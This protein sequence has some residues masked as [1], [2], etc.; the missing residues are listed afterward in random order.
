MANSKRKKTSG[1]FVTVGTGEK[2]HYNSNPTRSKPKVTETQKQAAEARV[3]QY[4]SAAKENASTQSGLSKPAKITS[5]VSGEAWT[6]ATPSQVKLPS[7]YTTSQQ[8]ELNRLQELRRQAQVDLDTDTLNSVDKRMKELRAQ[9]GKQTRF[10]RVGSVL[11]GS[12]KLYAGQLAGTAGTLVEGAGKLN[13]RIENYTDRE[14]LQTAEDNINRYQQMLSSGKDLTGKALTAEDR[15][16][17]Q[18]YIKHNQAVLDAHKNYTATVE[19]AD[20]ET[21]DTLYGKSLDLIDSG[22]K[23]VEK[24][25]EDLGFVGRAAVDLGVAGTQMAADAALGTL[26]G[27]ALIP[28]FIR[29]FGGG[30]IEAKQ[31]G[32]TYG[33]QLAY[34]ALSAGTE[35]ATEKISNVSG[36]FKKVYGGGVVDE[37][38]KKAVKKLSSNAVGQALL[39]AGASAGGEGFEEFVSD[40]FAPIWQRA[41]YAKDPYASDKYGAG[42]IDLKSRPQ[43]QNAD[44]TISTV[45]SWSFNIDGKEVLLPS[46]WMKDGKPYRSSNADEILRHYK[47]TGEYLGKFDTVEQANAYAEKLHQEQNQYYNVYQNAKFDL[48]EAMYDA[49]IGAAMGLIGD[50]GNIVNTTRQASVDNRGVKNAGNAVDV[51]QMNSGNTVPP[52]DAQNQNGY[53]ETKVSPA[54]SAQVQQTEAQAQVTRA[55]NPGS[56]VLDAATTLFTQQGMKLKTAQEKAAIVQKLIAGEEVSVRDI[57]KLNPTSKE[58][59]AIFTQLTGVQFPEGKV[60]QEQLYNLYRSANQVAVD[61]REKQRAQQAAQEAAFQQAAMERARSVQEQQETPAAQE[62]QTTDTLT[63]QM[64]D[65]GFQANPET[66]DRIAQAQA[67]LNDAVNGTATAASRKTGNVRNSLTLK[68]GDTLTRDQFKQVM[69]ELYAEKGVNLTDNQLDAAFNNFLSTADRGGDI[70]GLEAMAEYLKSK[71]EN[72]NEAEPAGRSVPVSGGLRGESDQGAAEQ[73]QGVPDRD[74]E[75]KGTNQTGSASV[76]GKRTDAGRTGR[77]GKVQNRRSEALRSDDAGAPGVSGESEAVHDTGEV[78]GGNGPT[79]SGGGRADE[80]R[81]LS[82]SERGETDEAELKQQE[83]FIQ[84]LRKKRPPVKRVRPDPSFQYV[85]VLD[86]S[87]WTQEMLDLQKDFA[88]VGVKL[89]ATIGEIRSK[90]GITANGVALSGKAFAR[91]DHPTRTFKRS[92][93][94]ELIHE[95][96]MADNALAGQ[97]EAVLRMNVDSAKLNDLVGKYISLYQRAYTGLTDAEMKLRA[98]EEIICDAYSGINRNGWGATEYSDDIRAAVSSWEKVWDAAHPN[99]YQNT[100]QN[101]TAQGNTG[102]PSFSLTTEMTWDEQLDELDNSSRFSALYI[103]ETPNILAEVGLGDLPLCMTKAHMKDALHEKDPSNPHWHGVPEGVV[104]RLPDLLSKPAMIL[105]SK[106]TPGD[107]VVVLQA[108]DADGNPIVATIRPNGSA[109]VDKVAGPAN[110]ITS[111]YGRDNFAPKAG[112]TSKNNLLYL[113]LRDR[114]IMYWN[115][116]RTETLAHRCRL[117]LPQTLRKV[118]SDTILKQYEGY[119]KGNTPQRLFSMDDYDD[120]VTGSPDMD[121]SVP[122]FK[123]WD[124]AFWH[125]ENLAGSNLA[126]ADPP[127]M[128]SEMEFGALD[129]HGKWHETLGTYSKDAA[130]LAKFNED[131]KDFITA[132]ELSDEELNALFPPTDGDFADD[133]YG[134]NYEDQDAD[135]PG[136]LSDIYARSQ[137]EVSDAVQTNRDGFTKTDTKAFQKWF[138]DPSGE[139]TNPDGQPKVFLRGSIYMGATKAHEAG[140]AKSKGIFFTTDPSVAQEYAS[141]VSS[142]E[143]TTL[144][145][146]IK[147]DENL[148]LKELPRKYFRGWGPAKDYILRHFQAYGNGLRLVG[149]DANGNEVSRISDAETFSLQ[150]NAATDEQFRKEGWF[151]E[152]KWRELASFPKTKQ[153][154]EDFNYRLGD[155]IRENKLG[156]RGY[157]KYFLTSNNTLVVDAQGDDYHGIRSGVLPS[158][159][160]NGDT[161]VHINDIAE[162]AFQNGYDAVVV[163]NVDDAGGAQT[164]YIV[165]D[166]NQVKSV[167]NRGTWDKT[168]PDFL[169]DMA[170]NDDH[171]QKLEDFFKKMEEEYGGGSAEAMFQTFEQLDRARQ[172]AEERA[173]DAEAAQQAAEW[174]TEA[175]VEAARMAERERADK[176]LQKQKDAFQEKA[177]QKAAE[178][179]LSKAKAVKSARLAEQMNAGRQWAAKLRRQDER[180]TAKAEAMRKSAEE[181]MS[182][183][184]SGHQQELDDTRLAE[185]MNAGRKVAEAKRKGL[186]AVA[187]EKAKREQD[188]KLASKDAKTAASVLRKYHKADTEKLTNAPVSTLREAYHKPTAKDAVKAAADKLRTAHREFYKAFIN[189][190]QAVDDFSKYQKVDAN[191]SVL[192]RTAMASGSTVQS[193]RQD[194]LV[195]KDGSVIDDRSLE[196]VVICWDGSGKH[197]KYND[198]KQRILQDYMLHRHNVDRMSFREKALNAVESYEQ[199]YPWLASLEPREFA[200]LVADGN[201]IAQRYQELIEQ[202]QKAKDK[203]IFTDSEGKPV[204]AE[205]SRNLV[206]QYEQQ[207]DWVKEKAEGIYDWWD[208]FMQEWVVGDSLSAEEYA[209]LRE[210]YPSYVPTYRKDKPGLGKGVSSFGGTVTAKKAVRAATGGTSAVAN[211]EDSFNML[212]EK[213]VSSQRTN[214]VLRSITDTAMLD[215]AGD[216]NGF[217]V[218]DWNEAPEILRWGLAAEGFEG[219]LEAGTDQAAAKALSKDDGGVYRVRAWANGERVSAIV[220]P[221]LY[222][223]LDFAFNQKTGWFTK[224]GQT[225]TS[226]MKTFITGINPAFAMRN[227]IRDNLTAQMNSISVV[228]SISGIK[229]EKYY[230]KAWQEM[231][232]GSENWQHFVALGGTNAGYYNNEGGTYITNLNRQ[233]MQDLNPVNKVGKALGFI[234]EH[235]EQVTRFAEYL[236]TIDRLPG[237]DTYGNRLVGIKNAAEVTVDFSRKGTLGKAFNAWIPY[238]NPTVQGIDKTVRTFFDQ[239][240]VAGKAKVL[241]RAALTTLP[242]DILLF[243]IYHALDRDDEWEELSDRTKDT[244]YC[245]PLPDE[246]K[247]LKIPKSRDWGQIIGNPIMRMLQGLDGREDPFENYFEVSIK[248]NFLWSNPLDAVLLSTQYDLAKNEDFAGRAIVPSNYQKMAKGD[249]WNSDTSKYAKVIADIGNMFVEEDVLSPMQIDYVINDYFGDFGSMFQRLFSIGGND[250]QASA[251]EQAKMVAEDLLGNWVADNRYSSATVSDYYDMLDKVSQEVA[252]ERVQNPDGYKDTPMYKLNSAFNAKG[253]ASDQITE[254]NARVRELPD[255]P[256]KDAIKGQIV[257]LAR[258]ALQMYDAVMS[259]DITEPK[260]EMEYSKYGDKVKNALTD[261]ADYSEDYAFLPSDYK[262]SSYTDPKNKNKEYVLDDAAKAKYRELYDEEYANVM[263]A[264][265]KSSKYRSASAE[266]RAELLEAV[267]DDVAPQVKEEFLKWLAKNYKSTPKKK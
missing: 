57:N 174:A 216:F 6:R 129:S 59:Q 125:F 182:Q 191:T 98:T 111:V 247:F 226:P 184:R 90:E 215:D 64:A 229:F 38:V 197:R 21:A 60:T 248:P 14:K 101:S 92:A 266:K 95:Y 199:S 239:P 263:E 107:I 20:K 178:A 231:V 244:Y 130:G 213:N 148:Y 105:R 32:A 176:K 51:S 169:F 251:E 23:D 86:K 255:G 161:Y 250:K 155:I 260:M 211:I 139:F 133:G 224:V 172:R 217:A 61:A 50:A 227:T 8:S 200:E 49:M 67:E 97:L 10:E 190:T 89:N 112:E 137:K 7:G 154:L 27:T 96:I 257:E 113:A 153:G 103:E 123:N 249:Q 160:R 230:A 42:N 259:G 11:S 222:K 109:W 13:T 189:G 5:D 17:I 85:R 36:V 233:K 193:I 175:A 253:S 78:R 29:S 228:N 159:L 221:E 177:R 9:A 66:Q 2:I 170:E 265:I 22:S 35:V 102:K 135:V 206:S 1:Y 62:Q 132:D 167:Y 34:G 187:R 258:E 144:M 149:L 232:S 207:Y 223:A 127:V 12:G 25:K 118:P 163:K 80:T 140:V 26:T 235:T 173:A 180:A 73:R 225:L 209:T 75:G 56:T 53:N 128:T 183:L 121:G 152:E 238:W 181:R 88:R 24:A 39:T 74:G 241:S 104:R 68:T 83:S 47:E 142:G 243:A 100:T 245:I 143:N 44:G 79:E 162:R 234:G 41:T 37:A 192:L 110:F 120:A 256:E 136:F 168:K 205:F 70:S 18:S 106:T 91:A 94:H 261:L 240:T 201:R 252:A 65:A 212:M 151:A 126:F 202:F 19:N 186:D 254:L 131:V 108:A 165:K 52:V 134:Y 71:E 15:K 40:V 158:E 246:H 33:Q 93:S 31:N 267:R 46:V 43:Y 58:G 63:R 54:A 117:Q 198:D 16:R 69:Q 84:E 171:R 115:E 77:E 196:D 3:Q 204:T 242:L 145:D 264:V 214:M 194:H 138:N 48:G 116:K 195:G 185:R 28:M 236:A 119:V 114:G 55:E 220:D 150:T 45:D 188:H 218:F 164:Q 203:P 210:T 156:I 262:P 72:I 4:R 208:K 147:G 166:S 76:R 219:A 179:R 87:Y 82:F 99:G 30:A 146:E 157:G 81:N 122:K 124:E 141:G 237:G